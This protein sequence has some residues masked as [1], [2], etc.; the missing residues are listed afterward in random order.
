MLMNE[1]KMLKRRA[2][3]K[4]STV[5]PGTILLVSRMRSALI[6][7]VNSPNVKMFIGNV[8]K[9]R[10]GFKRILKMPRTKATRS[11]VQKLATCTPGKR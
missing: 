6:T 10:I 7:K 2:H 5:K 11:A 4:P 8:K 9:T 1:T 3:Q